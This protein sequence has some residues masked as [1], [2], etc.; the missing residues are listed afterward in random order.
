MR[1]L[2]YRAGNP[3]PARQ[4]SSTR[5]RENGLDDSPACRGAKGHESAEERAAQARMQHGGLT[6]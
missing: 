3:E 4:K 6:E 2:A 5:K 1:A